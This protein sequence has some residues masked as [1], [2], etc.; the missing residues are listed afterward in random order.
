MTKDQDDKDQHGKTRNG[1]GQRG[2]IRKTMDNME[3]QGKQ[4]TTR[5]HLLWQRTLRTPGPAKV[6]QQ[7][8]RDNKGITSG[9]KRQ[10][11]H[12]A[13]QGQLYRYEYNKVTTC[14]DK[15]QHCIK[16]DNKKFKRPPKKVK[17][18]QG[19]ARRQKKIRS[20]R[21]ENKGTTRDDLTEKVYYRHNWNCRQLL[22]RG[23]QDRGAGARKISEACPSCVKFT[24]MR[25][26]YIQK[27]VCGK[28][29]EAPH[30][31]S[32]SPL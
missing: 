29:N 25:L 3:Q 9:N 18:Q 32:G 8:T 2:T 4:E 21:H 19:T 27:E 20:T 15:G 23:G 28:W 26:I 31:R 22:S 11:G 30:V 5:D 24:S 1:K 16:R 7:K 17:K 10:Q 13:Q 14:V 12:Q 6:H